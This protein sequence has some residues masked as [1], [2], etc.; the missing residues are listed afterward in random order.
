MPPFIKIPP[1]FKEDDKSNV[2]T[3][4][5]A[6]EKLDLQVADG[7]KKT[8]AIDRTTVSAI[9]K[10]QKA[11]K[12]GD[13]GKL[14]PAT[15]NAMN[16]LLHDNFV[17]ENKYRTEK[18]HSLLGTLDL[19]VDPKEVS[20]RKT[21]PATRN[22]IEVFQGQNRMT[23]NGLLSEDV[24]NRLQAEA[25][26]RRLSTRT[27]KSLLHTKLRKVNK[28]A[29]L[30]IDIAEKEIKNK[31][32]GPTSKN[33]IKA[34]QKKYKLPET[35]TVD[36]VTLDKMNGVAASKGTFVRKIGKPTADKLQVVNKPLRIDKVSPVVNDAQKALSFLGH[37][38]AQTEFK[39]RT[40][41]KTTRKAV[42]GFQK[43][44]GL[45][46][47]GHLEKADL[48]VLNSMIKQASANADNTNNKYRVRGSVRNDLWQLM[49]NMVIRV[50]EK[51]VD[52]E[53]PQPLASKKNF[54][55]GFFDIAYDPPKDPVTGQVKE[56]F[57]LV[58]K[59]YQP[60]DMD[61]A[62][63]KLVASQNQY[64]AKRTQWVNFTDGDTPYLGDSDFFTTD[65]ILRQA[66]GAKKIED[67]HETAD[68]KQ[69]TQLAVQTGVSP[70]D[71][72]RLI[73]AYRVANS[74]NRLNPLSPD[75]FYAFL[76]QNLP[77]GLPGDL[78]RGTADWI[79]ID[80][81]TELAAT[82]IVFA[83][84][85][86]QQQTID[87][88]IELN[89]VPRTMKVKRDAVLQELKNTRQAFVLDK[90]I[91]TGNQN[92]KT[93][94]QNSAIKAADYPTVVSTFI[95]NQGINTGF[96]EDL[97]A[98][99]PALGAAA[100]KD[101]TTTVEIGNI[102]KNHIP[103]VTFFKQK[104]GID[105][106]FNS[107]SS[108]AKLA[109]NEIVALINANG[110]SVPAN[111]PGNTADEK[112]AAYAAA[113]KARSG[114]LF[115]AS[116]LIGELKRSATDKLT[117]LPQVEKFIDDNPGLNF[118]QQNIDQYLLHKGVNLGA[119][120][121]EEVKLVQRA[122]KIAPDPVASTVL[123]DEGLHSSMQIYFAGK[124]K[125]TST[126]AE[127]GISEQK[128]AQVYEVA[129]MQ[130]MQILARLVEFRH[131]TNNYTPAAISKQVYT[132]EEVKAIVGDIPNLELLFGSLDFCECEHCKSLFGP[133]A[134]FTDILRFIGQHQSL[135]KKNAT[136]FFNVKEIL[137]QRRPDLATS[138]S[139]VR[140]LT[141]PCP[142][143]I[144]FARSWRAMWPHRRQISA[145]K[146]C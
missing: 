38:I 124:S 60:V 78:L 138:S 131:E 34:F 62:H 143:S 79:T 21:G 84:D 87:N 120:V 47:T 100:V 28:I 142:T 53:N 74:V 114:L 141:R 106:K 81:L 108:F 37:E 43:S 137:F 25:L 83:S 12:L 145:I 18:L 126:F 63:D 121:K 52:K 72:M 140:T 45:P 17:A 101:F 57:H 104:I 66:I 51:Q 130:Y 7:E 77:A 23:V 82:G 139:I 30:K 6:L 76:R 103:T 135:V 69:V 41:G 86:L 99:A 4:H 118:K 117:N 32:I 58:I 97:N 42:L 59:L 80:Q 92:L 68:D 89:L 16:E 54:P 128:A 48:K 29:G 88:A 132:I 107:A 146:P 136:T 13:D 112:V 67:L 115:P 14:T 27:Q 11:R 1:K 61:P 44:Q 3:L 116:S 105:P 36:K 64:D 109:Q 10:F 113:I 9:K 94:L 73:L 33:L 127:K 19:K 119:H 93:L 31:E 46:E 40:F 15:I 50:F 24:F 125:L 56:K 49:T 35:G 133:A 55:N 102:A 134:Y 39:T 22:A 110:K 98:K 91:L 65:K 20:E 26:T 123:V 95:S 129:K 122:H 71:I 85:E 96:W 111:I 5:K 2:A 144:S 8:K 70:D 90:P 75:V